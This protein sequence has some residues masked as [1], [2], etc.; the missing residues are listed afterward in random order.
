MMTLEASRL[1]LP[2][3][4]PEVRTLGRC[5]VSSTVHSFVEN[6]DVWSPKLVTRNA[7]AG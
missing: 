6:E 2:V 5:D 1:P 7:N 3:V 4:P